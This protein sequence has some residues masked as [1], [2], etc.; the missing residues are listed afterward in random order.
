MRRLLGLLASV[1]IAF[2]LVPSMASSAAN[3]QPGTARNFEVVGHNSL[4]ARGMNAAPAIYRN[5]VYVGNRTDGQPGH[6]HAGVLV[7]N[8]KDPASPRVVGEI[9]PPDEGV[10]GI[11]S[12]ELRVWPRKKLLMVMNFSCSSFIH[13]CTPVPDEWNI[14]FYDLSGD[15]ARHPQLISTY[16]PSAFPHEMFLWQD[17][18]D[19]DRAL[20]YLSTPTNDVGPPNLV[21]TDISRA[22][23]GHF[24]EVLT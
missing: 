9:G 1:A 21:V 22:R 4:F 15:N 3:P 14:K 7:V 24:D 20:L 18:D 10:P 12:R 23:Q 8:V 16:V 17:P 2:P 19:P 13:A 5:F 11:T 6:E